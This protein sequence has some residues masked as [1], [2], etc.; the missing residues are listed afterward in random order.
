MI[1][2]KNKSMF[3]GKHN[4]SF[5]TVINSYSFKYK[6][7]LSNFNT[8]KGGV[9]KLESEKKSLQFEYSRLIARQGAVEKK[10]KKYDDVP[11]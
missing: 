3:G 7:S 11:K 6:L 10:I 9:E 2:L 8:L 4:S 1:F 5:T